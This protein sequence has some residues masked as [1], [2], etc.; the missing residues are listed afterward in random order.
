MVIRPMRKADLSF[1][2][3]GLSET[4]WQDIPDDQKA[5]LKKKD[6][7]KRIFDEFERYSK[8]RRYE[9]KVFVAESDKRNPL[10]YISVGAW[11]DRAVG[12]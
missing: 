1:D 7:D 12:L 3:R 5:M 11:K 4:N 10:G 9:F 2:R 8:V 6:S